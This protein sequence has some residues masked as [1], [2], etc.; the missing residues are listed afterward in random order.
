M[1]QR[2]TLADIQTRVHSSGPGAGY[3]IG[4]SLTRR[5]EHGAVAGYTAEAWIHPPSKTGLIVLRNA[6]GGK[7]DLPGFTFDAMTELANAATPAKTPIQ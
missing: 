7:F 2:A 3:G 6:S 5:G 4:F 1:L